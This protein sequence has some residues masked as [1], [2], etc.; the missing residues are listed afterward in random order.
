[1]ANQT[2]YSL[3]RSTVKDKPLTVD[4]SLYEY[5]GFG[6]LP[7]MVCLISR[8]AQRR[9][10]PL[11]DDT[12]DADNLAILEITIDADRTVAP[13]VEGKSTDLSKTEVVNFS[14]LTADNFQSV[15]KVLVEGK[16][17][18][19]VVVSDHN[20]MTLTFK[21]VKKLAQHPDYAHVKA[22]IFSAPLPK[23][24]KII[25]NMMVITDPT[26]VIDTMNLSNVHQG[27]DIK[28]QPRRPHEHTFAGDATV[29][30]IN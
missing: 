1:M 6:K 2:V 8:G 9:I 4:N 17:Y 7:Y 29:T 13:Q 11:L 10:L 16:D 19:Q 24:E 15:A 27:V 12:W 21:G 20:I 25:V 18:R 30:A 22:F 14:T 3:Q 26:I 28:F 5:L 23:D